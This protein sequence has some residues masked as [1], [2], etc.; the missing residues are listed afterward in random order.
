MTASRDARQRAAE[1]EADEDLSKP[2]E[3]DVVA[4]HAA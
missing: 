2:F 1:V 3:L 4:R